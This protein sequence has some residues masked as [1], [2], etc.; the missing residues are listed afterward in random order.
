MS[1]FGGDSTPLIIKSIDNGN[2][3][4]VVKRLNNLSLL[5]SLESIHCIDNLCVA[6]GTSYNRNETGSHPI[7]VV[8]TDGGNS[9]IAK[10]ISGLSS[11]I[12]A[13]LASI[14]SN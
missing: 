13:G 2:S 10:S 12:S 11:T 3:W 4:E 6:V 7:L 9:W 8:S 14:N 5:G 1:I